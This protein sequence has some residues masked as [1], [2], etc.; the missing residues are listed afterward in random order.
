MF[1]EAGFE[2]QIL[3]YCDEDGQFH[4]EPWDEQDGY[5][6]RSRRFDHRNENGQLGFVSLI[7]DAIKP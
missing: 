3:E 1:E 2:V 5:I 4:Y 6:Y 7:V